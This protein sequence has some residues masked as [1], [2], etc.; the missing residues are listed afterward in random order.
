MTKRILVINAGSSSLKFATFTA[1]RAPQLELRGQLS[2]IGQG[3]VRLAVADA[4][5]RP[6]DWGR[7][8]EMGHHGDALQLLIARLEIATHPQNWLGAG[9]RVVHGGTRFSIPVSVDGAILKE[10][11]A[12]ISLAPLHQPHNV[13]PIEALLTL[14]P[15][16]P[17]VAC[18]DTAFHAAQ[19]E[20]ARR[21]P[22]PEKFWHAGLRRYGFHGLSYEA[23]LHALPAVAGKVASRLVIAHLGNGASMAA[24]RD[25]TCVATTMGFSTL[26]GLVM[27]TRPG[28][29]DPGVLLHLLREGMTREELER[30]LYHES[31]VKGVSGLTADMK[32]L[33][34]S[35]DPKARLAIDLYCYRIARELGSL[36]AAL[37]GLDALVFTGGV[38]ENA[39]AIR[40]RVCADAAWLGLQLDDHANRSR[41]AR[42]ST[43]ASS[44]A[45]WVVPTDEELTIARHTQR[46]LTPA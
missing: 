43:D 44:V 17:Q 26:D 18:F 2:G 1:D 34:E 45:A 10:L 24:I 46:L 25:G 9:H 15:S 31:G 3:A 22:L 7:A 13:A 36:A 35:A 41:A 4:T 32:T 8:E 20:I 6:L 12:L 28:A 27:G 16:L 14:L 23:I 38:G 39:A 19:P 40:A 33:L 42:I 29:I 37:G 11:E 5:G 30:L 21:F